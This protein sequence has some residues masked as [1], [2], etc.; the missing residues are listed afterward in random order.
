MA[1]IA[2]EAFIDES[3]RISR[4]H[5][6]HRTEFMSRVVLRPVGEILSQINA[7]RKPLNQRVQG[8]SPCAPTNVNHF[9]ASAT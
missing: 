3:I 5:G 8:S 9:L 6:Y 4:E 2:L 1:S 7:A